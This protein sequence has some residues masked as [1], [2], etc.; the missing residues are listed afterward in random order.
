MMWELVE[1]DVFEVLG[2]PIVRGRGLRE[3]DDASAPLVVVVNQS[4]ARAYWPGRRALGQR[5]WVP[6]GGGPK[7]L[8]TVVGVVADTRYDDLT[9][10]RPA[11]Y[12]PLRQVDAFHSNYLLVRTTSAHAPVMPIV[13]KALAAHAPDSR[14]TAAVSVRSRLDAPLIRPRFGALLLTVFAGMALL[15]AAAGVYGIMAFLVRSRRP[16]IGIRLACGATPARAGARV[17]RQGLTLALAGSLLGAAGAVAS[18][19]LF[20]AL[21]Y[22]VAPSDPLSLALAIGVVVAA[23]ALACW[24]PARMAAETDPAVVLRAE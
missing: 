5:L 22:G 15:L 6:W 19:A 16:E 2:T 3:S 13:R 17:L 9:D 1:P 11:I 12:Y 14:A 8:W 18:G 10:P 7:R 23:A 24:V 21:L 20:R 4:A